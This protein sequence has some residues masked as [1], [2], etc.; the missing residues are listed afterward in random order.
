MSRVDDYWRSIG[1]EL[2]AQFQRIR[3]THR[4]SSVKGGANEEALATLLTDNTGGRAAVTR[5]SIVD[6]QDRISD[7]V[8]VAVLNATQ[9]FVT[10]ASGQFLL[11][12]GVDA[13][14]QVKARLDGAELRRALKNAGSVKQLLRPLPAGSMASATDA[15]GP[16]FIDRIPFFIFAYTARIAAAAAQELLHHELQRVPYELQPDG[17]FVLDSW[18]LINVADNAGQFQI[19]P[20]T[21]TGFQHVPNVDALTMMLWCH[22]LF[23][24][25]RID[26]Q[27]PLLGYSPFRRLRAGQ[28][29]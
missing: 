9:P 12:H 19:G 15:D 1:P 5:S 6:P 4:D 26:V 22:H 24:F 29:D 25:H 20:R 10:G 21:S 18:S 14:Y 23:V 2:Q 17:I 27:S 16:R 13:A 28:G 11:A 3:S 7:E 8:D